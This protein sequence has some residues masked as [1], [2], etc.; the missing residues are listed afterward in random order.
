MSADEPDMIVGARKDARWWSGVG[1][2]E[3]FIA[4]AIPAFLRETRN[5]QLVDDDE[6]VAVAPRRRRSSCTPTGTAIERE[7][8]EIDWDDEP[9]E[10]AGYAT[11]ML[12]EIH[13]QSDAVAETIADR[14][15]HDDSV[16]LERH[17]H[18]STTSSCATCAAS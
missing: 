1:D 17:R 18:R 3:H 13:E 10:K 9:A 12:K 4:S 8:E 15:A 2:G 11:F 14:L 6:I 7:V 16:D 5:V